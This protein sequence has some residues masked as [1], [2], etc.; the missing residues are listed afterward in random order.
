MNLFQ[1]LISRD[2]PQITVDDYASWF[3][4]NG[5]TYSSVS[6][7][8]PSE[9]DAGFVSRVQSC[10]KS[11]GVVFAVILARLLILSEARFQ[12][13]RLQGGRP[14]EL[15]GNPDLEILERPWPNGTTGELI[16]RMEQ[17]ASLAGNAYIVRERDRLRRL[18]PDWVEIV[19]TKAPADSVRSDIAGY[20]Y[21]PGG[22]GDPV[23]YPPSEVAHWSPIPDP[24]AQ[25]R[26]MSWISSVLEEVD[27]D[28]KATRHKRR[29]FDNGASPQLAVSLN[30]KVT[31]EQFK[32]F[33]RATNEAHQGTDNAYKTL[34]LGGGADVTAIGKDL[35]QLDFKNTQGAGE[36]RIAAAAGVPAVIVGLSE[37]LQSATYSNFTQAR[38]RFA[39]GTIRP[40]WRSLAASLESIL[41]RPAATRL[42]YDDRDVPILREDAKDLADIESTRAATIASLVQAGFDAD[43]VVDAVIAEDLSRLKGTHSGLFSV[44]LQPPTTEQPKANGNGD[45]GNRSKRIVRDENTGAIVGIETVP[46]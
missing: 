25:Y 9:T 18:R 45:G 37:G 4:Y 1:K 11:N 17:D 46:A 15:F 13:Q 6:S 32:K 28:K 33:I 35:R 34:Y 21:T 43:S 42:W 38:R 16:A 40:L 31:E 8:D 14:G 23:L 41:E 29:F 3:T 20:S 30:E 44:Q 26:G 2:W 24:E 36:T 10:Y 5:V 7:T 27:A 19:L 39:D 12:W 22:K